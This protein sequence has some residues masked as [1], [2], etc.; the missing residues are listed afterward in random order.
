MLHSEHHAVPVLTTMR[1][2]VCKAIETGEEDVRNWRYAAVW[3]NAATLAVG[4][5]PQLKVGE[6]RTR[7]ALLF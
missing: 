2:T 1:T 3:T 6:R 5:M 4:Q 7:V